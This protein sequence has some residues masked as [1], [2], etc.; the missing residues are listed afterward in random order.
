MGKKQT[1]E[2]T[3]TTT[4]TIGELL[5]Y[6][7]RK[8]GDGAVM[9]GR[10][11]IVDVDAVPTGVIGIDRAFGCGGVP[12]G[13][14]M[15]LF[16]TE[17]SGKTTTTLRFVSACQQHWFPK[18]DRYGVAAFIDAEHSLDPEWADKNGV[19]MDD[20]LISQ[21]DSGESALN[22]AETFVKSGQIDLIVIDSVA[23]LVPQKELDGEVGDHHVGA[24]A[25]MMSQ[26]LRKIRGVTSQ[27]RATVIFI[28][29]VREKVGVVFGN[30]ETTPGGKALKYY[31]TIRAQISRKGIIKDGD[32]PVGITTGIKMVKN[33]AAA[34]F[35]YGEYQICFGK[36][37]RP[38]FGIDSAQSLL[39]VAE[40]LGIVSR[41]G[42]SYKFG[43]TTLGN[44]LAKTLKYL[45]DNTEIY[46]KI[47]Q[48]TYERTFHFMDEKAESADAAALFEPPAEE[49]DDKADD[50]E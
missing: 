43:N 22:L 38:I 46:Q 9:K 12:L 28:N 15:E 21:P 1:K 30:P 47:E 14:V 34:P 50:L 2:S 27:H 48:Q 16:G 44:G 45:R 20:L 35:A 11:A 19:N 23:A 8:Y 3:T 10:H 18:K 49:A 4:N 33:K 31:A 13:R 39:S 41:K 37:A 29:Q 24:Q 7:S 32:E 36:P 42:S 6:C 40:E 17:S 26:G 5:D 25:R